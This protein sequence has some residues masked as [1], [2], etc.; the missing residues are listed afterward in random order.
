MCDRYRWIISGFLWCA[1]QR[2]LLG[3]GMCVARLG[4]KKTEIIFLDQG[5]IRLVLYNYKKECGDLILGL[6]LFHP[7]FRLRIADVDNVSRLETTVY[8]RCILGTNG[9]RVEDIKG[10]YCCIQISLLLACSHLLLE[11][12]SWSPCHLTSNPQ[13]Q[14]GGAVSSPEYR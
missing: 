1:G 6:L 11:S 12:V 9:A 3:A 7:I 5:H 8:K 14:Q 4:S 2:R 10:A 13:G